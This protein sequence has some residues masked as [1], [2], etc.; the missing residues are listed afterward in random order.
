MAVGNLVWPIRWQSA[1][2]SGQLGA[3]GNRV[4][5]V[6]S[7]SAI[8]SGQ[9]NDSRQLILANEEAVGNWQSAIKSCQLSGSRQ[10]SLAS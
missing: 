6:K 4:W 3:V 9:L 7:Q 5:P 1:T 2:K 10:L 8:K